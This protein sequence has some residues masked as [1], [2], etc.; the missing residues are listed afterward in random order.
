MPKPGYLAGHRPHAHSVSITIDLPAHTHGGVT[1]G[2]AETAAY[3]FAPI[4]VTA[5]TTSTKG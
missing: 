3:D 2:E 1:A 4:T 5:S